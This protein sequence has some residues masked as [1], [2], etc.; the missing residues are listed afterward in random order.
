VTVTAMTQDGTTTA[1]DGG[2]SV[3][4]YDGSSLV[5]TLPS[6][7]TG[8]EADTYLYYSQ[9]VNASAVSGMTFEFSAISVDESVEMSEETSAGMNDQYAGTTWEF[10]ADGTV[11]YTIAKLGMVETG[12]YKTEGNTI[13]VT[14]TQVTMSGSTQNTDG[15]FELTYEGG[16]VLQVATAKET[17]LDYDLTY[18]FAPVEEDA[19]EEVE[20][21]EEDVED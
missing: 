18:I 10:K 11:V 2:S 9:E 4:E 12:T 5:G 14:I 13:T 8:F 3:L 1:V 19:Q 20:E 16:M 17:G 7:I 21:V 15:T 6:G